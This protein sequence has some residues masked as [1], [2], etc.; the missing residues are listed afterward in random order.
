[1]RTIKEILEAFKKDLRI[2]FQAQ[3]NVVDLSERYIHEL[4]EADFG[5]GGGGVDY[6]TEMQD[7]G[8]KWIDGSTIYQQTFIIR[9]N[10]TDKYQYSANVYNN[11]LPSGI[12]YIELN[13]FYVLRSSGYVDTTTV[14]TDCVMVVNPATRSIYFSSVNPYTDFII[15]FSFTLS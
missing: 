7:T 5:G 6:S 8:R 14:S 13:Q 4:S 3:K 1:M 10:G 2:S 9:Q 15:T 11:V 12:K